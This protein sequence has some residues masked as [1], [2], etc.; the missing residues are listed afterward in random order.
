MKKSKLYL[1]QATTAL[2]LRGVE[3]RNILWWKLY[4]G[5]SFGP[6]FSG[7]QLEFSTSVSRGA[8]CCFLNSRGTLWWLWLSPN[9]PHS[10]LCSS[11]LAVIS[12]PFKLL[13]KHF[14]KP[15]IRVVACCPCSQR[16]KV[17][18]LNDGGKWD[19]KGT[20]HVSVEYLEVHPWPISQCMLIIKGLTKSG[21]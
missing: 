17:Y 2:I 7:L 13:G 14:L 19:D 3:A 16:V 5:C 8:L 20:G 9:K 10:W 12:L 18:R 11:V 4:P 15:S 6:R 1:I 21:A